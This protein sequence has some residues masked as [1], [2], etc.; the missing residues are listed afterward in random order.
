MQI[1][2]F[3]A[4]GFIGK[5]LC[6]ALEQRGHNVL[7]RDLR[8]DKNWASELS[9]CDAVI[10]LGGSP[11]FGKRWNIRIKSE[12]YDSRV[13][14]TKTIVAAM[15]R[16]KQE[17]GKDLS[18]INASAIGF[19]GAGEP[20]QEFTEEAPPGTDFLS[21]VCRDWEEEAHVAERIHKIRTAIVRTGIVLGREGGALKQMLLPFQ[22]GVGGPIGN[23]KQMFSWIHLEDILGIYIHAVENSKVRGVLNGVSPNCV[24]NKEFSQALAHTLHRPCLFPVPKIALYILIGEGAEFLVTGQKVFPKETLKSGYT[25]K[26]ANLDGALKNILD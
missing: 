18:L 24:S 23:G 1:M 7:R 5:K 22:L 2:I 19:Y 15:G 17:S 16:V 12:I 26:F 14:G 11:I 13:D 25:F 3:G 21:F 10:N 6:P 4:T 9:S 20:S 8:R